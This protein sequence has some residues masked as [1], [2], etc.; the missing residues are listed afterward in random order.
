M[1]LGEGELTGQVDVERHGSGSSRASSC[2]CSCSSSSRWQ[3]VQQK[4]ASIQ[5]ESFVEQNILR[6]SRNS[7]GYKYVGAD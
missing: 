6:T 3:E 4:E 1:I 7:C 5:G 2:S